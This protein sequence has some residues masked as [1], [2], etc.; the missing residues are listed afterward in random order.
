MF[1]F[2]LEILFLFVYIYLRNFLIVLFI[3]LFFE[4]IVII[5]ELFLWKIECFLFLVFVIWGSINILCL[6]VLFVKNLGLFLMFCLK[7]GWVLVNWVIL[8]WYVLIE[9][10]K[11]IVFWN[12]KICY[13]FYFFVWV[14]I[15][16]IDWNIFLF[17]LVLLDGVCLIFLIEL[18]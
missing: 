17:L 10:V 9:V 2:L 11:F 8:F 4:L 16:F 15:Y 6:F 18:L 1:F 12:L 13:E 14:N 3:F 7:Y 5:F